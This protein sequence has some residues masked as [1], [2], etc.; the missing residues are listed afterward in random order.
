[1]VDI[2]SKGACCCCVERR[3]RKGVLQQDLY[4]WRRTAPTFGLHGLIQNLISTTTK[5]TKHVFVD[6]TG[7]REEEGVPLFRSGAEQQSRLILRLWNVCSP[8][9]YV[10][11]ALCRHHRPRCAPGDD[12]AP[13]AAA[14]RA[15]PATASQC[16]PRWLGRSEHRPEWEKRRGNTETP[17]SRGVSSISKRAHATA[18]ISNPWMR[19]FYACAEGGG[20]PPCLECVFF[21]F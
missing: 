1:M 9:V 17:A 10:Q 14:E 7:G 20:E 18:E 12:P 13:A 15:L 2:Y 8:F 4:L 5:K 6:A 3:G 11:A 21:F 16:G 19:L